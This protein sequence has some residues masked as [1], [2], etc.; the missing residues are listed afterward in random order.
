MSLK[1]QKLGP[2]PADTLELGQQ[3]LAEDNLMRCIGEQYAELV[4][5]LNRLE[6]VM[7]TLRLA[8]I[9]I[10]KADAQWLKNNTPAN[11]LET[12][13]EWTQAERLVKERGDKG[14]AEQTSLLMQTARDGF[15]LLEKLGTL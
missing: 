4:R 7:E 5:D 2:I 13:G 11:W 9:E 1:A 15:E 3:L 10:G 12:Y 14:K 6:L 8:L